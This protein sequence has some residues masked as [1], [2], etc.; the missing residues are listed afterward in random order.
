MD[1]AIS[2]TIPEYLR[3]FGYT[4]VLSS[5]QSLEAKMVKDMGVLSLASVEEQSLQL[6][7]V[8]ARVVRCLQ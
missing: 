4:V 8:L 7:L 5:L 3:G 6:T 2:A 1:S